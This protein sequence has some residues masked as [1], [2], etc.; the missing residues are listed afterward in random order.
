L[1]KEQKHKF[2]SFQPSVESVQ[3]DVSS[4]STD[5]NDSYVP[6]TKNEHNLAP[7]NNLLLTRGL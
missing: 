7:I 4:N 1:N 5:T 3:H 6:S 2:L